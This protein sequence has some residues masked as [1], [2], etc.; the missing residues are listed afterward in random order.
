MAEA[1]YT[2]SAVYRE[3]DTGKIRVKGQTR[4]EPFVLE[5]PTDLT[6]EKINQIIALLDAAGINPDE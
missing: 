4:I 5:S 2:T 1:D 3:R 6:L